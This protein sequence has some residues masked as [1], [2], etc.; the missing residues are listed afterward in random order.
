VAARSTFPFSF[1][2]D[3]ERARPASHANDRQE[4]KPMSATHPPAR[5]A[6]AFHRT[7]LAQAA[8]LACLV[9]APPLHCAHAQTAAGDA[10]A[11]TS[12]YDIPAGPLDQ[13]LNRFAAQAGVLLAIDASLTTGKTSA[14]LRTGSHVPRVDGLLAG[15]P[16]RIG[17]RVLRTAGARRNV[18]RG[19]AWLGT[20][21][22]LMGALHETPRWQSAGADHVTRTGERREVP[23]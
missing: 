21:S 9:L 16:R 2:I 1:G 22:L 7:P 15:V 17:A 6:R 8:L 11:A 18:L 3:G 20:G 13:A 14:G 10:A 5:A 12:R 19:L 23:S 4:G